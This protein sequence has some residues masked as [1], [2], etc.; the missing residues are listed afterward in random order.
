MMG[1]T[2]RLFVVDLFGQ[3]NRRMV[4]DVSGAFNNQLDQLLYIVNDPNDCGVHGRDKTAKFISIL[5]GPGHNTETSGNAFS[6]DAMLMLVSFQFPGVIW[7]VRREDGDHFNGE[8]LQVKYH[9]DGDTVV[10]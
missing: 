3:R 7:M 9:A 8:V 5:D 10:A 6:P 4:L 2:K 1:L